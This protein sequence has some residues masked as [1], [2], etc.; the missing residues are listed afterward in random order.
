[1]NLMALRFVHTAIR[2]LHF[3]SERET[4]DSVLHLLVLKSIL[5]IAWNVAFTRTNNLIGQKKKQKNKIQVKLS[6]ISL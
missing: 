1:M 4:T 2:S 6:L 5:E 3:Y